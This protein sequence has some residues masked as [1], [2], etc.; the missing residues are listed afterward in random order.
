MNNANSGNK[1]IPAA[2]MTHAALSVFQYGFCNFQVAL[3][4]LEK[5]GKVLEGHAVD[6]GG[7]VISRWLCVL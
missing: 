3:C 4:V 7:E 2:L 1:E 6:C 5:N